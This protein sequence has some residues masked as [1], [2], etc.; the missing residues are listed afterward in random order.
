MELFLKS[1]H[2]LVLNNVA[3]IASYLILSSVGISILYDNIN[4]NDLEVS[5]WII[6]I[7][8]V[9]NF[10]K[11]NFELFGT[12][13]YD[14]RWYLDET[15]F[16][17]LSYLNYIFYGIFAIGVLIYLISKNKEIRILKFC[18]SI[19][20]FIAFF[21]ILLSIIHLFYPGVDI[22]PHFWVLGLIKSIMILCVS[23]VLVTEWN[24]FV[25]QKD[26]INPRLTNYRD[27]NIS[28]AKRYQRLSHFVLDAFIGMLIFSFYLMHYKI[29]LDFVSW[30]VPILGERFTVFIIFT[31]LSLLYY[32]SFESIL[33]TTPA[34]I[35]TNTS[36]AVL[37]NID[38][39]FKAV[40]VRSFSRKIPFESF[41]FFGEL[42]W[43]DEISKITVVQN[44]SESID[45]RLVYNI[46]YIALAIVLLFP[47]LSKLYNYFF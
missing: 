15:S 29:F 39:N 44:T 23:Y 11:I 7:T 10:D 1:F 43:H 42:G 17:S 46:L 9:V 24:K 26:S 6:T 38:I 31:I 45:Y 41:S 33:K 20:F 2:R 5:E 12:E 3:I 28:R 34:K 37:K 18:F 13:L 4:F 22:T 8:Q 36:L 21:S 19:Y 14:Y 16:V 40:L 47:L 25:V 35:L 30:L 27:F 32:I